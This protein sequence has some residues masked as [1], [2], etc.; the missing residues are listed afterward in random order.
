MVLVVSRE[1]PDLDCCWPDEILN[2]DAR[3]PRL[4][5]LH[6]SAGKYPVSR[7]PLRGLPLPVMHEICEKRTHGAR[8]LRSLLADSARDPLATNEDLLLG[9]IHI[10]PRKSEALGNP[11]SGRSD[12]E[13]HR[14]SRVLR[15]NRIFT[16]KPTNLFSALFSAKSG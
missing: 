2:H 9:E 8:S 10:C 11:Q 5:A 3:T 4:L 7:L 14:E 6:P 15:R 1:N 16:Q 12:Q 13:C